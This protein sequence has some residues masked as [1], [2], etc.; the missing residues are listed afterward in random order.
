MYYFVF[1]LPEDE[2]AE[3][4][5]KLVKQANEAAAKASGLLFK[6]AEARR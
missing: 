2:L 3:L 1:W 5:E 4:P 6:K